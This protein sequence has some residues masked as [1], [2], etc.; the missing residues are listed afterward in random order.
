MEG[1]K[2]C[3]KCKGD[4]KREKVN[5]YL[6]LS[7][8]FEWYQNPIPCNGV[9]LEN[10]KG[11][12]L[13]IRRKWPP[14]KGKLDVPGGFVDLNENLEESVKREVKEELGVSIKNL[15][16]FKSTNPDRYLFQGVNFHTMCFIYIG[17]IEDSKKLKALD[18]VGELVFFKKDKIPFEEIGF[19]S[20]AKVIR[21]YIT[22]NPGLS[23]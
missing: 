13:L 7:C 8:G 10:Q 1:F 17:K 5:M 4:L 3:P 18:D 15:K 6:C 16:F 19:K 14:H 12:I 2:F 22:S 21:E 9:I 23:S 20:I 11:E